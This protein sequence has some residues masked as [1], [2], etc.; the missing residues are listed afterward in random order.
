MRTLIRASCL[1]L[2]LLAPLGA[3]AQVPI[4]CPGGATDFDGDGFTDAQECAGIAYVGGLRNAADTTVSLP[5]CVAGAPRGSCVDPAT[6][7][8]FLIDQSTASLP[9]PAGSF[10][11]YASL[12]LTLHKLVRTAVS[13]D[14]TVIPLWPQKAVQIVTDPDAVSGVLGRANWGTPNNLDGATLY[15]NRVAAYV[16]GLCPAGTTCRTSDGLQNGAP[17]IITVLARWVVDHEVGH[18]IG[19]SRVFDSRYGGYHEASGS[20]TVM[21]QTPKVVKKG[22]VATF[23]IAGVF[24]SVSATDAK[25]AGTQ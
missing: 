15:P 12:G 2:L 4:L 5:R 19:L 23:Y 17:A 6:R 8:L 9:L 16:N 14:R 22:S 1:G 20:L 3:A 11:S 24:S 18:T 13:T 21:E 10:A 25:V 7:D